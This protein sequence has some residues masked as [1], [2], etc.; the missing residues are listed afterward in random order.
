MTRQI[1]QDGLALIK[2]WEAFIPNAYDDA[3]PKH[4]PVAKGQHI[5]GTLTIGYGHTGSDVYP[6]QVIDID[7]GN[8]LLI[9][10]LIPAEEAVD[11]LVKVPLTDNQFAALVAFTMNA[12]VGA[13]STST[14]LKKLNQ[15]DTGSV[16]AELAK[17]NKTTIDGKKIV[18]GGLKNRRAAEAGL[19]VKGAYVTSSSVVVEK[20]TPPVFTMQNAAIATTIL[21]GGGS[22][23]VTGEGPFQYALA[24]IAVIGALVAAYYFIEK[25]VRN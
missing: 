12:G 23:V 6:G 19:F 15:G 5:A 11:R 22:Q 24:A 3:D 4:R 16:P 8:R 7:E 18:S 25:R 17:W 10:D 21:T 2:Q 20:S 14:L 1:N 13:L 9:Q